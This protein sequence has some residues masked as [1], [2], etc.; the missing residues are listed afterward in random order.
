MKVLLNF[1]KKL[2]TDIKNR[3]S[4][5]IDYLLS[6]RVEDCLSVGGIALDTFNGVGLWA[7]GMILIDRDNPHSRKSAYDKIKTHIVTPKE[8]FEHIRQITPTVEN[9]FV[10]RNKT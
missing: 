5:S 9:A 1:A 2:G 4:Y 10:F 7:Y 6:H 8:A 3:T